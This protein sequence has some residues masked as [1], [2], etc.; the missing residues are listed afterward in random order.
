MLMVLVV[1]VQ[2]FV[3]HRF[4]RVLMFVALGDVK[5]NANAHEGRRGDQPAS[6]RLTEG[7]DGKHGPDE[8]CRR[9]IGASARRTELSQRAHEQGEAH[10]VAQKAEQDC[11]G[12]LRPFGPRCAKRDGQEDVHGTGHEPLEHRNLN[13]VASGHL[14]REV[15]V[16][17]P[18]RAGGRDREGAK[19][20]APREAT[21]P[22]EQR[23][24]ADDRR[25]SKRDPSIDV[26]P[27]HDPRDR[28]REDAFEIEQQRGSRRRRARQPDEQKHGAEHAAKENRPT[29]PWCVAHSEP[30]LRRPV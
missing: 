13:R 12:G 20:T 26:L 30:R 24:A 5:P 6:Q 15:V 19:K 1:H 16:D 8:R 21:L 2:M 18:T 11:L 9:E 14:L 17:R 29:E 27:E 22:R 3:F 28:R 25:H 7:D 10:T 4:V 23:A